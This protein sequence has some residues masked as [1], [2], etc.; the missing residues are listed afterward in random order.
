MTFLEE[1]SIFLKA[2]LHWIY[3]FIGFSIFFFVIGPVCTTIYGKSIIV[4]MFTDKSFAVYAFKSLQ[5]S[6]VP[7]GVSLIVTNPM[8]GFVVQLEIAI[9]LAFIFLFPFFLYKV[10]QYLSPALFEHEKK[11]ILKALALSSGLFFAG[12]LF[13]YL[14]MIPLTF[15]LMYPF[16]IVLGVEPFFSLD[17]FM[18]WVICILLATGI[19]FLLPVFMFVLSFLKII[20]H[21][22]WKKRWRLS[23]FSLLVFSAVITPDQTGV[24]MILLFAPL[25]VLYVVG[26]ILTNRLEK[27]RAME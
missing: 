24:T 1:L 26:V 11:I 23:F 10:M 14:Y 25:A 13:A 7:D 3:A 15:K 22:F 6:F 8:S 2:I 19:T 16:T 20:N 17:S 12:C 18:S 5:K 21:G 4:P 27:R 9:V